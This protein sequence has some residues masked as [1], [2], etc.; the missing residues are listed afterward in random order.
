M[1][2]KEDRPVMAARTTSDVGVG[3]WGKRDGVPGRSKEEAE[4]MEVERGLDGT[5]GRVDVGGETAKWM[6]ETCGALRSWVSNCADVKG[7]R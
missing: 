3:G 4:Y 1:G 5:M 2:V 6:G 7:S